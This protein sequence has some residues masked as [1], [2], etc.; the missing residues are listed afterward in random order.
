MRTMSA[1][2]LLLTDRLIGFLGTYLDTLD[3]VISGFVL[4]RPGRNQDLLI[5]LDT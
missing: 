3:G 1:H 5:D 4:A 2:Q